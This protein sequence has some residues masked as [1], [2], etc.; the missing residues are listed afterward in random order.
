MPVLSPVE[1][2]GLNLPV[3]E[4]SVCGAEYAAARWALK[5][6]TCLTCGEKA[7]RRVKHTVAPLP[8]SNYVLISDPSLLKGL[9][10][11]HKGSY[12]Q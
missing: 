6:L 7:A 3:P 11:S 1:G 8:K 9:N 10:T 4:C 12:Q 2:P 5:Y